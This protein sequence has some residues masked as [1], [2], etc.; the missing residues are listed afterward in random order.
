MPWIDLVQN[1]C[2]AVLAADFVLH[3]A[4]AEKPR[5]Y[6]FSFTGLI[7]ASAV[8]FFFTPQVRSELLL[9][10]FKF[11]RILRVFKLLKFIDEARV[12]GQAL[13]GSAR[14]IGVF[15]FFVFLL[16]VVLG[17]SIFVIESARPDSQFQTVA[18]GVYWAIVTMTTVGYGDVVPQTELGRLLA[19]VV[20]LLG[21]GIIAISTGIL[22]VSGCAI[23][24]SGRLSWSAAAG[25]VRG[26][27]GMPFT[28]MPA[29]RRCLPGPEE[30]VA[31]SARPPCGIGLWPPPGLGLDA[32]PAAEA[33]GVAVLAA[34]FFGGV[35][36]QSQPLALA[37]LLQGCFAAE[38]M[39]SRQHRLGSG[40]PVRGE[41]AVNRF[42]VAEGAVQRTDQSFGGIGSQP[43]FGGT[44]PLGVPPQQQMLFD[45]KCC[46]HI[47]QPAIA[48]QLGPQV[49]AGTPPPDR[50]GGDQ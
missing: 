16:Q 44:I 22:T 29:V 8:L 37:P 14:T 38:L 21:F 30:A 45:A 33:F 12:L 19:S 47:R 43:E 2:L 9:W 25:G 31:R 17:Y 15:L 6:L 34:A 46:T 5:R 20:M 28:A 24:S 13:R 18:S 27:A 39:G 10:V 23:T 7:D 4:S 36:G 26:T 35:A 40:A 3:L 49:G 42:N 50:R 48:H 1:V 41:P 32:H 11:G